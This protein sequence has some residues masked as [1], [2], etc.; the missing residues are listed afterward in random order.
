MPF[1]GGTICLLN[2]IICYFFFWVSLSRGSAYD[3]AHASI[4]RLWRATNTRVLHTLFLF[5]A[6]QSFHIKIVSKDKLKE[7]LKSVKKTWTI[8]GG[9]RGWR[10]SGNTRT[11]P[12][13]LPAHCFPLRSIEKKNEKYSKPTWT[14]SKNLNSVDPPLCQEGS[15]TQTLFIYKT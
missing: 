4:G 12:G 13:V 11:N 14:E 15:R 3:R 9:V 1:G 7:Q 10:L 8:I 6:S 5:L 2:R